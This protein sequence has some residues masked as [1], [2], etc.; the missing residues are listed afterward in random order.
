MGKLSE[1]NWTHKIGK[2]D[3]EF[4]LS[5]DRGKLMWNSP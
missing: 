4:T 3:L 2:A 5:I 1:I